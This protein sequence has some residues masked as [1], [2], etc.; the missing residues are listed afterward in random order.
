MNHQID[1]PRY[2]TGQF[3]MQVTAMVDDLPRFIAQSN[4]KHDALNLGPV[5]L[6]PL[7]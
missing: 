7:D 2:V 1:K 6:E 3:S 4:E 5:I